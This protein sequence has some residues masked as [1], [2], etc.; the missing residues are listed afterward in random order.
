MLTN[1]CSGQQ[2]CAHEVLGKREGCAMAL[3]QQQEWAGAEVGKGIYC[4]RERMGEGR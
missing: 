4:E 3:L 1:S 2:D